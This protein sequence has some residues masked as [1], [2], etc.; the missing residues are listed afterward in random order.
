MEAKSWPGK[1][2]GFRF[3][4]PYASAECGWP[5]GGPGDTGSLSGHSNHRLFRH[6]F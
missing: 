5:G 3:M 6:C 2:S 4:I 1:G